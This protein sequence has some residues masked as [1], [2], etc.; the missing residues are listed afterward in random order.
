MR[1]KI[2]V[3]GLFSF[4]NPIRTSKDICVI[5]Q[6]VFH[7]V[8]PPPS[9]SFTF[10]GFID[11]GTTM[12][13]IRTILLASYLKVNSSLMVCQNACVIHLSSSP[14]QAFYHLTSSQEGWIQY[15]R[16]FWERSHSHNSFISVC[17]SILL[18]TI[19]ANLLLCLICKLN[20]ITVVYV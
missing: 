20:F 18:L 12:V 10:W 14:Q 1:K 16:I 17:W 2:Q 13:R 6:Q 15:N 11:L 19:V 9:S 7:T 4:R 3:E 8:V 5:Q